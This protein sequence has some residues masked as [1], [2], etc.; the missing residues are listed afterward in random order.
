V[1]VQALLQRSDAIFECVSK[2]VPWKRLGVAVRGPAS[3][4]ATD[5][6]ER[7]CSFEALA[8]GKSF[9]DLE[10]NADA[11]SDVVRQNSPAS[12]WE[13]NGGSALIFWEWGS[14]TSM[15]NA[16]DG[17]KVFVFGKLPRIRRAQQAP[18]AEALSLVA[19]KL[20]NVRMKN[21]IR[22]GHAASLTHYSYVY[23]DFVSKQEF[24][25]RMIYYG[26]GCRLNAAVCALCYKAD[27][28][29]DESKK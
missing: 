29:A 16:R 28:S 25:I 18:K 6:R 13:W 7:G 5:V 23:K 24:D 4:E 11:V 22:S 15:I 26:T 1:V 3:G 14:L 20:W 12:W 27:E 8:G 19:A 17:T 2:D 9:F 21:Y 10:R